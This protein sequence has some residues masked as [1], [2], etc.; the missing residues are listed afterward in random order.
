[1]SN[2]FE[3]FRDDCGKRR[4]STCSPS[5][6]DCRDDRHGDDKHRDDRCGRD[7]CRDDRH[8]RDDRRDD[9][10]GRDDWRRW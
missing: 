8:D 7:G 1:M 2:D 4:C 6:Y 10:H 5:N 9:R 3:R